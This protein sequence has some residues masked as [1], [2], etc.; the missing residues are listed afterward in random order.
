[1]AVA[2]GAALLGL[3]IAALALGIPQW[4]NRRSSR[5]EHHDLFEPEA[6]E[7]ATGRSAAEIAASAPGESAT[8]SDLTRPGPDPATGRAPR[9][10]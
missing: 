1:M 6:Y 5:S 10:S 8:G 4:I 3:L 9:D 2:I 7:Q